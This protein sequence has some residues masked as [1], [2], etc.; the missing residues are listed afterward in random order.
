[1]DIRYLWQEQPVEGKVSIEEI[2]QRARRYDAQSRR[3]V[4][5]G[6]VISLLLVVCFGSYCL[7]TTSLPVRIG[8]AILAL[9]AL[10]APWFFYRHIWPGGG[11]AAATS[12]ACLAHYRR[13]LE[14][15][16]LYERQ[17]PGF[18]A[19]CFV[20]LAFLLAPGLAAIA[21]NMKLVVNVAPFFLLLATW[22]VLFV[23][24]KRRG[25]RH[26]RTELE[27]LDAFE[28]ER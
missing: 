10:C 12:E 21:R 25:R 14:R 6:C 23:I 3:A 18:L 1:L 20:G 19:V 9:W 2:R 16:R 8:S 11:A 22:I 5:A 4:I 13:E 24:L 26:V 28:R 7:R 17:Q 27:M 15:R